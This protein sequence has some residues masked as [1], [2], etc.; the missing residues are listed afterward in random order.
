[1]VIRI[2]TTRVLLKM[3]P[4][5]RGVMR[6]GA[7]NQELEELRIRIEKLENKRN[8]EDELTSEAEEEI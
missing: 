6:R 5:R 7:R 3:T 4:R 1:M 2:Q 8:G